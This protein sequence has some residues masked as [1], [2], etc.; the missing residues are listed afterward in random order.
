V[1]GES[2]APYIDASATMDKDGSVSLFL[3][4]RDLNKARDVELVWRD[5]SPKRVLF[6]QVLTGMDLKAVNSF[7]NPKNVQPQP[8]EAP[9]LGSRTVLQLP[10]RSY[11][12]I[13]FA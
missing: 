2:P 13:Q 8:F 3:L 6:S 11:T 9:K 12:V 7:E 1:R 4:N 5:V 10:A